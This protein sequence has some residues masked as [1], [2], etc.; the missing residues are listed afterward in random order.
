MKSY[1]L[2]TEFVCYRIG[3]SSQNSYFVNCTQL[4]VCANI[5]NV[6]QSYKSS[7]RIYNVPLFS[8]NTNESNYR[9]CNKR[10]AYQTYKGSGGCAQAK[11][12]W[13][14]HFSRERKKISERKLKTEIKNLK[15]KNEEKIFEKKNEWWAYI[16]SFPAVFCKGCVLRRSGALFYVRWISYP[17]MS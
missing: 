7:L 12:S 14:K 11:R 6:Y 4:S 15:E 13:C 8:V 5:K 3:K 1:M 9:G 10:I 17:S 16:L 2:Y